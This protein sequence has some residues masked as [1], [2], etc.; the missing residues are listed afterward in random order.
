MAL[1]KSLSIAAL[2]KTLT[3]EQEERS[4]TEY[5]PK[6]GGWIRPEAAPARPLPKKP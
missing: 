4:R 5:D 3:P 6:R 2:K 1:P